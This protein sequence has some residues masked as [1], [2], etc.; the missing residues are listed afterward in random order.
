M[1]PVDEMNTFVSFQ[2]LVLGSWSLFRYPNTVG[3]HGV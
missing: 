1:I 3:S 2:F